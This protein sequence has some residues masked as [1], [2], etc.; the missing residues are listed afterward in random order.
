MEARMV[1]LEARLAN[2]AR[3]CAATPDPL[4]LDVAQAHQRPKVKPLHS[5]GDF[6]AEARVVAPTPPATAVTLGTTTPAAEPAA[7]RERQQQL[8]ALR[9]YER[10][11]G[12]SRE[13]R[14]ALRVLLRADRQLDLTNPWSNH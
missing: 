12:L 5:E 1:D 2:Q 11:G 7:G 10:Q 14:E 8:E 9:E 4:S 3:A 6:L 13:R